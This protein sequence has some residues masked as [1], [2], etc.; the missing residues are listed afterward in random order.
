[1]ATY[2]RDSSHAHHKQKYKPGLF[3]GAFSRD[4]SSPGVAKGS[5]GP[6]FGVPAPDAGVATFKSGLSN[7]L[8]VAAPPLARRS[9][10]GGVSNASILRPSCVFLLSGPNTNELMSRRSTTS[11]CDLNT[12]FQ[13][14]PVK[15]NRIGII[16]RRRR[17]DN[18]LLCGVATYNYFW[19]F[20]NE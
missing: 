17:I 4:L 2:N 20:L 5:C 16:R 1:M 13:E 15:K 3:G 14:D 6:L 7:W 10:L 8:V 9:P 11:G 19:L 18:P 12:K